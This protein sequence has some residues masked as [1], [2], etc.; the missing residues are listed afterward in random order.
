MNDGGVLPQFYELTSA[1][2]RLQG[3]TITMDVQVG[4]STPRT[5]MTGG[6]LEVTGAAAVQ[7]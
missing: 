6:T 5:K 1:G 7:R 4:A 3:G 2:A